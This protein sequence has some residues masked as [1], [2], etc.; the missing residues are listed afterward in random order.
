[1]NKIISM[2]CLVSGGGLIGAGV[3]R[4]YLVGNRIAS[5]FSKMFGS[6][7]PKFDQTTWIFL[8]AGV[9]LI[10]AGVWLSFSGNR[11]RR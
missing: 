8:V 10:L 7:V 6:G 3:Q 5:G 4:T 11:R 9:L 2:L 1:M